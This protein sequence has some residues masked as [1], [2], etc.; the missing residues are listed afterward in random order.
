VQFPEDLRYTRENEWARLEGTLAVVGITD[1]AQDQLGDIVFV[2][3][4]AIG[5]RVE[6]LGKLGEIESVKAVSE[7]YAPIGGEV[8]ERNEQ[9]SDQPELVN[10]EP[11]G[12][13]WLVKLRP[14]DPAELDNLLDAAKY[15]LLVEE[16]S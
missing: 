3:L 11:Y 8:V 7:L 13:G 14:N 4:P 9:L 12:A 5:S 6:Q 15:R 2:S 16:G 1:Y 10:R